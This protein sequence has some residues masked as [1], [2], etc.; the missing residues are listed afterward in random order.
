MW[1]TRGTI[2]DNK[3]EFPGGL[4]VK[5]PAMSV[6]WLWLLLWHRFYPWPGNFCMAGL[7]QKRGWV[8]EASISDM[9]ELGTGA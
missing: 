2:P 7:D 8:A 3:G 1:S 4:A 6:L 5:D 9:P